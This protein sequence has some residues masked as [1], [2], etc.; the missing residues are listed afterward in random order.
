MWRAARA[1]LGVL[2]VLAIL[3]TMVVV[4]LGRVGA[5]RRPSAPLV[6]ARNGAAAEMLVESERLALPPSPAANRFDT[7]WERRQV[8]DREALVPAAGSGRL[9]A[10]NLGEAYRHHKTIAAWGAGQ[11]VLA[12]CSISADGPGVITTDVPK[13]AYAAAL[14]EAIGWHRHWDRPPTTVSTPHASIGI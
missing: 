10:V 11:D 3:V 7:G 2:V 5:G 1:V 6:D 9:L 8:G 13:R 4:G 12:A 14:I